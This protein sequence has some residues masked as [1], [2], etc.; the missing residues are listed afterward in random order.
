MTKLEADTET[1]II[2]PLFALG[3]ATSLG[4][5]SA[6]V[7]PWINLGDVLLETG[8]I[9]WTAGRVL[10]LATLVAVIVN[11]DTEFDLS[12]WGTIEL[13]VLYV[14]VGLIVAPPFFPA[15]EST[16]AA[17]PAAFVAFTVQSIGYVLL[18]YIN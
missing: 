13:W 8:G 7:L 15:L 1:Y 11:R 4:L 12:G 3:A 6:D 17:T 9:E 14:T 5:L 10:S 18:T 16:L 2:Y